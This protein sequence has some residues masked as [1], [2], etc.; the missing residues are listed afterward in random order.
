MSKFR[1]YLAI[2]GTGKRPDVIPEIYAGMNRRMFAATIDAALLAIFVQPIMD[3]AFNRLYPKPPLDWEYVRAKSQEFSDQNAL[4]EW[5]L[6]YLYEM[7]IIDWW[8]VSGAIQMVILGAAI[9]F[10]WHR[11]A[12]TP[13]KV[14]LRMKI[15]DA[16]SLEPITMR[17]MALRL[18]GYVLS[19]I[20]LLLGFFWIGFNKRRQGWHDKLAHTVVIRI[21]KKSHQ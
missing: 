21:E 14:L 13:G 3:F 16:Q 20:P 10:C 17:Q 2:M 9:L 19:A 12:A 7:K 18:A 6:H 8:L 11:W 15:V 1:R 5:Y 4:G